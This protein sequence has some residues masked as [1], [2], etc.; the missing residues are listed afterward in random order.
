M[1]VAELDAGAA[2]QAVAVSPDG[3]FLYVTLS[4]PS[5]T[6]GNQL[7]VLTISQEI[8]LATTVT[9]GPTSSRPV[10]VAVTADGSR[11]YVANQNGNSLAVLDRTQNHALVTTIPLDASPLSVAARPLP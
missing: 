10:G 6:P 4:G 7:A 9:V 5:A 8:A 3:A 1:T 2:P 11:I